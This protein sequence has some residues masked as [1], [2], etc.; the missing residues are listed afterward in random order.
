[1]A[2]VT[3]AAPGL[4]PDR[5]PAGSRA[6]AVL[7]LAGAV[8]RELLRRFPPAVFRWPALVAIRNSLILQRDLGQFLSARRRAAYDGAGQPIGWYTYPA[9]AYFEQVDLSDRSVFEFGAGN[10]TLYWARR[11]REVVAV[12]DVPAWHDE[13]RDRLPANARIHLAPDRAAYV[14]FLA[15]LQRTF[16]VIVIDGSY[17]YA[18]ARAAL[19]CLAPDGLIVVDNSDWTPRTNQWLREAGLRQIDFIGF[20]PV[21]HRTWSTSI[22][23]TPLTVLKPRGPV[24]PAG[25]V[26][27]GGGIQNVDYE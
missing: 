20:G 17:R 27:S 13:L 22:F 8:K 3:A 18:C 10:S 26:G 11:A 4:S 5:P 24:Q 19:P 9:T 25:I 14:G 16:D 2:R 12:E 23:I 7:R 6:R 15:T 1:M 21:M